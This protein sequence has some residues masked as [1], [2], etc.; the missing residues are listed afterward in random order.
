M[1][2]WHT[3]N[4]DLQMVYCCH[5]SSSPPWFQQK[6]SPVLCPPWFV[7][8]HLVLNS[9]GSYLSITHHLLVDKSRAQNSKHITEVTK[10]CRLLLSLVH[11]SAALF[12]PSSKQCRG[13][14][15]MRLDAAIPEAMPGRTK[16]LTE[17]RQ[18]WMQYKTTF[19]RASSKFSRTKSLNKLLSGR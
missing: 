17:R 5:C 1:I 2:L 4:K 13:E 18:S 7:P 8:T 6:T 19:D 11:T 3:S 12:I 15:S 14:M 9:L 10:W 16:S